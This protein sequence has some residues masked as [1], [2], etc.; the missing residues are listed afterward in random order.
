MRCCVFFAVVVHR[1]MAILY[2]YSKLNTYT[3][4]IN[5][6]AAATIPIAGTHSLGRIAVNP[7]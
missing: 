4:F 5:T 1:S 7:K 3:H 6:A 2:A